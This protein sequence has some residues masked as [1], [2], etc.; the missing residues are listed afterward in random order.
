M[1]HALKDGLIEVWLEGKKLHGGYA[2][3]CIEQGDNPRWLII[4][5]DDDQ[6]DARRNPT[7]TQPESVL[8]GRNLR[9]IAEEDTE[10]ND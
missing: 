8:S 5:M 3:K 10:H 2:I 1:E 4:K 6:A 9:E 7:S